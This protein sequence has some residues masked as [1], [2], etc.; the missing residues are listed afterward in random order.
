MIRGPKKSCFNAFIIE[1][2]IIQSEC[3]SPDISGVYEPIPAKFREP[4]TTVTKYQNYK[5]EVSV[6]AQCF[7]V[8]LRPPH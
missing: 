4:G 6:M 3:R 7:A 8:S 1:I 5:T 2:N